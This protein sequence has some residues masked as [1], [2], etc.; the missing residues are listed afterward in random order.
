MLCTKEPLW[1]NEDFSLV[2]AQIRPVPEIR[3][4]DLFGHS[5]SFLQMLL[6]VHKVVSSL[7]KATSIDA[8]VLARFGRI[9]HADGSA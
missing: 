5:R 2:E 7:L 9:G 1:R 4:G 6:I 3:F 8:H